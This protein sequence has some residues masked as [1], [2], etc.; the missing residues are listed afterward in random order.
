MGKSNS[1]GSVAGRSRFSELHGSQGNHLIPSRP[2]APDSWVVR[3]FAPL[4]ALVIV[5]TGAGWLSTRLAHGLVASF[6]APVPHLLAA[7]PVSA[8]SAIVIVSPGSARSASDEA[9]PESL[10]R[11]RLWRAVQSDLDEP[12]TPATVNQK[13]LPIYGIEGS[14]VT[15]HTQIGVAG[16]VVELAGPASAGERGVPLSL[17]LDPLLAMQSFGY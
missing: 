7:R 8:P 2:A 11:S 10:L 16:M 3:F 9:I 12:I 13:T 4:V 14:C 6:H 17:A 15:W 1:F 5:L